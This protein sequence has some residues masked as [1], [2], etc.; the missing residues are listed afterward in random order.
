MSS[1]IYG[2]SVTNIQGQETS[3][4]DYKGKVVLIVNTASECGFTPQYKEL[5]EL[6]KKYQSQGLAILGFP[7]NQ[8]GAQEKGNSA[9]ISSFCELNFGVTFPLFEKIEV[10]GENTAPLYRHLKA[11]AKGLFGSER[12]KWNF[13]KFLVNKQG[14]VEKRFAST[15]KP[16]A[17]EN[18]ILKLL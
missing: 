10:N 14:K 2:F 5:E 16:M 8:F 13:T 17:I 6:Y 7:C 18:D 12:I 11:E 3:L 1:S 4:E 9:E 15:T